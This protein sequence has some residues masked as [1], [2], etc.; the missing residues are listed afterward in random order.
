MSQFFSVREC[1]EKAIR[2]KTIRRGTPNDK[3]GISINE[4]G[5]ESYQCGEELP[6]GVGRYK[7]TRRLIM[8]SRSLWPK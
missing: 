8:L 2:P 6:P 7:V 4:I 5:W 1:G 3:K